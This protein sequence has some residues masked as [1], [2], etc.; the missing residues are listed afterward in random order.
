MFIHCAAGVR[1]SPAAAYIIAV[2][3]RHEDPFRAAHVLFQEAPF[4]DPNMLMIKHADRLAG[5]EGGMV[6]A[7]LTTRK[8]SKV[9]EGQR[10]FCL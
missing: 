1:R 4:V 6:Q 5:L 10:S 3:T 9:H 8:S 2:I 7:I